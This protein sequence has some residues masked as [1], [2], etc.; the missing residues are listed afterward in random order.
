V[1]VW[2]QAPRPGCRSSAS[3]SC[4]PNGFRRGDVQWITQCELRYGPSRR[5]RSA[6]RSASAGT[7]Q[8]A[9]RTVA[10]LLAWPS[11][12]ACHLVVPRAGTSGTSTLLTTV[13]RTIGFASGAGGARSA[14]RTRSTRSA[15]HHEAVRHANHP[16]STFTEHR[17]HGR[18][19]WSAAIRPPTLWV[20]SLVLDERPRSPRPRRMRPR[21]T[22][23]LAL[24][25]HA[26]GT[27]L[28]SRATQPA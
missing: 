5:T 10:G 11:R 8:P 25:E 16:S 19:E 1:P 22:N 2:A 6:I 4:T 20:R 23:V 27:G 28:L 24:R 14:P 13:P 26:P 21:S 15:G 9:S 18:W 12:L 3:P 7:T 17:A